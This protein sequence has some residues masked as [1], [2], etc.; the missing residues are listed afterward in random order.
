M[1]SAYALLRKGK[2]LIQTY[3]KATTGLWIA[4]GPI[5]VADKE[6]LD[7]LGGK[8]RDALT[9]STE[10][11]QHPSQA[12]WKKIQAPMLEAAGVKTWATLAKSAQSVGI[13]YDGTTVKIVPSTGYG[14][15]GGTPLPEQTVYCD[16][17]SPDLGRS[18]MKAF[19][20]CS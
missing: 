9:G 11:V 4:S 16:F 7:D 19:E 14:N 18:L 15:N 17:S 6:R 12:E 3:S 1:K 2:I 5:Y 20:A 8:I 13:E 10:G